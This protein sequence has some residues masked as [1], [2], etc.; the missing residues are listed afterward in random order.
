MGSLSTAQNMS[1]HPADPPQENYAVE[2]TEAPILRRNL[3]EAF[4]EMVRVEPAM[5]AAARTPATKQQDTNSDGDATKDMSEVSPTGVADIIPACSNASTIGSDT[6]VHT[7]PNSKSPIT[8]P[9]ANDEG[10]LPTFILHSE[11]KRD[12]SQAL[13]NRVSFYGVIRDINQEAVS[14]AS[15]DNS[16]FA[17]SEAPEENEEL[18]PL[19]MAANGA[20]SKLPSKSFFMVQSALI[21][22]EKWLLAA[23]ESRGNEEE[24]RAVNVCPPTFSEAMGEREYANPL[25]S[26]QSSRTQLWKPSRSWWEAKSGKNPWIEPKSHNKRWRYVVYIAFLSCCVVP[27]LAASLC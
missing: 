12:L 21:D 14:M 5:E 24:P 17:R 1:C 13:V 20:M 3:T 27:L 8:T 25:S 16:S 23:I 15:H 9:K 18:S 22:E 7:L 2:A 19:V 26:L 11:L 6:P 10:S 4:E